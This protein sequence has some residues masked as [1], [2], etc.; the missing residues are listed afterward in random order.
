MLA[1]ELLSLGPCHGYQD[2]LKGF[3]LVRMFL[4]C[5]NGMKCSTFISGC[6]VPQQN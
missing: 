2:D 1:F 6:R 4:I 3:V 5:Q